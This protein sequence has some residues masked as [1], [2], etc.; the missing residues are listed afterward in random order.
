MA[1]YHLN[2]LA[3]FGCFC[4]GFASLAQLDLCHHAQD[5]IFAG[6]VVEESPLAHVGGFGNVFHGHIR[7]SVLGNQLQGAS[8]KPYPRLGGTSLSP[9]HAG[10]RAAS[11]VARFWRSRHMTSAHIRLML[12]ND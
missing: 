3:A 6:E 8:E 2:G 9:A 12:V 5:V 7:Q 10:S 1:Q 11:R 4:C